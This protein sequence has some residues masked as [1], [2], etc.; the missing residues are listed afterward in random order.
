MYIASGRVGIGK[1]ELN[2]YRILSDSKGISD[3][4]S[5]TSRTHE[6]G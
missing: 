2:I 1:L 4:H 6:S 5:R 3:K